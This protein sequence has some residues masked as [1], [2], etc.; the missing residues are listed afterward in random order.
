MDPTSHI[1]Y[2]SKKFTMLGL[3]VNPA[4]IEGEDKGAL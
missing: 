3:G 2:G 4:A 1:K